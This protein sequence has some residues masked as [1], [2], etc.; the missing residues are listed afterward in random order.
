MRRSCLAEMD[1]VEGRYSLGQVSD[2]LWASVIFTGCD[3]PEK[4]DHRNK[5]ILDYTLK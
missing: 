2:A 5:A 1:R 4:A 3:L